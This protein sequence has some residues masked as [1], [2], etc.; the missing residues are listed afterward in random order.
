M[1]SSSADKNHEVFLEAMVPHTGDKTLLGEFGIG[2][3][4]RVY[5]P[6]GDNLLDEKIFGSIHLALGENRSYGGNN[7]SSLHWDMIMLSPSVYLNDEV[8]LQNGKFI[9]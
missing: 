6:M 7:A 3:N 5:K 9:L 4:H 8:F 1:V 2:T